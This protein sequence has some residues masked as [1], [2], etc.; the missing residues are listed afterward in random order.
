[1]NLKEIEKIMRQASDDYDEKVRKERQ[2]KINHYNYTEWVVG[3]DEY[4]QGYTEHNKN[5]RRGR[6]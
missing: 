1:M 5:N 3:I 2:R 4:S 6:Y